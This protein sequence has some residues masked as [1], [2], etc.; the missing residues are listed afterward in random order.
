MDLIL[1]R[2]AEALDVDESQTDLDR[3]LTAKGERQAH[4]V[5]TWLNRHLPSS[6]RVLVSPAKRAQQ[7]VVAL[8]RKHKTIADLAPDGTVEGLLHAVRW[9]DAREP[10][11]VVGH[12]PT[13]GLTAAYLLAGQP[14]SWAV[15]KGA[16]WWLRAREPKHAGEGAL[17]VVLHA[18][19]SPELV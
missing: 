19:V 13:L 7:T 11:L 17:E 18:V 8:E 15:R 12:Q 5:A 2:H 1:W 14:Q 16:V 4:R 3:A 6:T 9:P 10:V